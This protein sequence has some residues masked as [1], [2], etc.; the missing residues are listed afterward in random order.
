M[1]A[2]AVVG[3]VAGLL[4]A[5]EKGSETRRKLRRLKEKMARCTEENERK[6][7]EEL[8]DALQKELEIVNS[9]MKHR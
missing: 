1:S 2:G 4:L 6:A 5:P 8:S 9:K 3:L 7:L